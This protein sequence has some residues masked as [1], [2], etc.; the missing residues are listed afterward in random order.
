M[1]S[2]KMEGE[3][4]VKHRA[5]PKK[6]APAAAAAE[7]TKTASDKK[8]VLKKKRSSGAKKARCGRLYARAVFLGYK[9]SLRKQREHTSLLKIEGCLTQKDAK[10]YLGKRCV[11]LYRAETKKLIK[12]E[13]VRAKKRAI[14]GKVTRTHGN[15]GVV[16][17]K[18]KRNLPASAMGKRVRVMLY[19]SLI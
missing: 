7:P 18:F 12:H 16:R 10:W 15:S 4:A 9:R 1:S 6:G 5:S 19:P 13:G 8:K 14:W 2:N 11:F 3:D 17:A